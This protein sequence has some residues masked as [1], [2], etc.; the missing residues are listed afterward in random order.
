MIRIEITDKYRSQVG[1]I[2]DAN[3][4]WNTI[5]EHW[6]HSSMAQGIFGLDCSDKMFRHFCI[7]HQSFRPQR[8]CRVRIAHDMM[9]AL[10]M[11]LTTKGEFHLQL[12]RAEGTGLGLYNLRRQ[13]MVESSTIILREG[14]PAT[15]LDVNIPNDQIDVF[16]AHHTRL[17]EALRR[18]HETDKSLIMYADSRLMAQKKMR[19]LAADIANASLLGA[20]AEVY[21]ESKIMEGVAFFLTVPEENASPFSYLVRSKMHDAH[22]IILSHFADMPSLTDL[23]AMVG[24]N[25]C[26]LKRAFKYEFGTTVFQCLFDYRMDLATHY[27]LDTSLPI[28]DIA[29]RL[30]YDYQSHFC[31]AFKRKFGVPPTEYRLHQ[32]SVL[33]KGVL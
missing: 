9:P 27:L 12:E 10:Q 20:A 18:H 29:V 23:A 5:M 25:E 21:V 1:G 15:T 24:T 3:A 16:F 32:G 31:T 22:D 14:Q 6:G 4:T 13:N 17:L 28:S 33:G 30:G 11:S 7:L 2:A 8:D 26:T 19:Q